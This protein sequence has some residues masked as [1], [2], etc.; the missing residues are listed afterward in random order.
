MFSFHRGGQASRNG[1]RLLVSWERLLVEAQNR[2]VSSFRSG[3]GA[4]RCCR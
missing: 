2:A 1:E 4:V 3:S